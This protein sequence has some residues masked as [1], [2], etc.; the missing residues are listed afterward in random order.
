[1]IG[2]PGVVLRRPRQL[3]RSAG[4]LLALVSAGLSLTIALPPHQAY[5]HVSARG[6]I[7]HAIEQAALRHCDA[8]SRRLGGTP[9]TSIGVPW[10]ST[11]DNRF[12]FAFLGSDYT[13]G[14]L[15]RRASAQSSRWRVVAVAAT[16]VQD[17]S[18]WAS[19]AP[20]AVLSDLEIG[21]LRTVGGQQ[22]DVH[23]CSAQPC[24]SVSTSHISRGPGAYDIFADRVSCPLARR[25]ARAS[26]P[27]GPTGVEGTHVSFIAFGFQCHGVETSPLGLAT[28]VYR[29]LHGAEDVEFETAN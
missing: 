10:V 19:R 17:C 13:E 12:A 25:V 9:C 15:L 5:S 7:R 26:G 1:M 16:S 21:G 24:G 28:V 18:Y 6:P 20:A 11:A 3:T 8:A 23:R 29:C 14:A 2:T 27:H 4:H 22:F